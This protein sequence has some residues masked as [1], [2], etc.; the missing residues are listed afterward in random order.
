M[1]STTSLPR[2]PGLSLVLLV[3]LTS[4][5]GAADEPAGAPR[6]I[7]H[8]V[9]L[10]ATDPKAA[11]EWYL[12]NLGGKLTKVGPFDAVLDGTTSFLFFKGKPG[13]PSSVGSACDHIGYSYPD[14]AAK[15]KELEAAKVE[16]VSGVE[17][18]GSIRYAFIKDPWGTLIELVEDPQVTGF[19]HIHLAT[20][21]PQQA[22]AWYV[23]AFGGQ[24]ERYAG[25]IPGVR[26][27]NVWVLAKKVGEA[28]APT[29]GRAIDHVSWGFQDL[30]A[31]VVE[32]K[33]HGI[34]FDSE[35]IS[36]GGGRIAFIQSPE[37]VR[38]ELVGPGKKAEPKPEA[39]AEA[40]PDSK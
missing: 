30:D 1:T 24:I 14:I 3:A 33:A 35:P 20:P 13:F 7:F 40:K 38:I 37:G 34:K 23:G 17:Q 4:R 12:K 8:H 19:H 36:F 5:V 9:H 21:D 39:K 10:T 22:L 32:L 25:L 11:V 29:K 2:L 6:A 28:Q 16:I 15:L 26:Y 18:E 31:A 27:G